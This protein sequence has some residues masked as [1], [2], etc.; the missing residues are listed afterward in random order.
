MTC[1]D[2]RFCADLVHAMASSILIT[3]FHN[4]AAKI[5]YSSLVMRQVPSVSKDNS[6]RDTAR[7]S[8]DRALGGVGLWGRA[9]MQV[10]PPPTFPC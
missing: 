2:T 4:L 8:E 1:T 10:L 7:R 6:I 9:N 5:E 3:M